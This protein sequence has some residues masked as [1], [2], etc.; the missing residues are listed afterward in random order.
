MFCT[1]INMG[2]V[3]FRSRK[4]NTEIDCSY[5]VFDGKEPFSLST[6]HVGDE[7]TLLFDISKEMY[8]SVYAL[9]LPDFRVFG[10]HYSS[11]DFRATAHI[12]FTVIKRSHTCSWRNTGKLQLICESVI[13]Q[14]QS[15]YW[16]DLFLWICLA[17]IPDWAQTCSE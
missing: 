11:S 15:S 14:A 2:S 16:E 17:Q 3:S 12:P 13:L 7:V 5:T 9:G 6:F 10:D 8:D 4:Y 1:L